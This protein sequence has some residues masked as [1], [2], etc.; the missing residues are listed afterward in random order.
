MVKLQRQTYCLFIVLAK[1]T[2]YQIISLIKNSKKTE[3]KNIMYNVHDVHAMKSQKRNA[4]QKNIFINK[5]LHYKQKEM[6]V[7]L[8]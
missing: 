6:G 2:F 4:K 5:C 1:T 8:S 3:M 7:R